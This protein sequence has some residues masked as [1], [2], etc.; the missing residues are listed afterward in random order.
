VKWLIERQIQGDPS[1]NPDATKGPVN[2]PVLLWGPYLWADGMTPRADGLVWRCTDFGEDGTHPSDPAG[3]RKVANLLLSFFKTDPTTRSWFMAD[4]NVTPFPTST[5]APPM[6]AV[7]GP[8]GTPPMTPTPGS[9]GT[10]LATAV[11]RPTGA[12]PTSGAPATPLPRPTSGPASPTA[13]PT[14]APRASTETPLAQAALKAFLP[15]LAKP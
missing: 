6:T 11:P 2:A 13:V 12:T 1:L 8:R 9:T 5:E 15:R 7:P 4:P 10:P 3:R 14:G